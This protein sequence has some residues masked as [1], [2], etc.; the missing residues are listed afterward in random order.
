M[1]H[2]MP[3]SHSGVTIMEL[4]LAMTLVGVL[5][6]L[7]LPGYREMVKNNCLTAASNSLV[8]V[9]ALARSEAVSRGS[10]D[11]DWTQ[12][13]W[14]LKRGTD[15]LRTGTAP[16][17]ADML[18]NSSASVSVSFSR[19]GEASSRVTWSVCDDRTAET[20]RSVELAFSGRAR[21]SRSTC[22]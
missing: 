11:L 17:E 8:G 7:A 19:R 1:Q 3:S 15:A 20:G 5:L 14:E 21:V 18:A 6:V 2:D 4:M 16:C 9:L 13:Q 10:V 22:T 12:G